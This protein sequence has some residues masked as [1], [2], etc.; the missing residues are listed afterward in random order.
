MLLAHVIEH[1]DADAGVAIMQDYLPYLRPGG[2]VFFICPQERGYAS[3]PTHVRFD[4]RRRPGRALPRG[5]PPARP[6]VQLPVPAVGRE[7]V[8]LQRVLPAGPQARSVISVGPGC[9]GV[10][11]HPAP[12]VEVEQPP[13]HGAKRSHCVADPHVDG[14]S[15]ARAPSH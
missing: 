7:A 10:R 8:H 13:L 5:G 3:D 14:G 6:V 2:K 9:T 15:A 4:D 12:E 1:M 11:P